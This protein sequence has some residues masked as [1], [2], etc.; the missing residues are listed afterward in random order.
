M[1]GCLRKRL[2]GQC[3][4]ARVS[5]CRVGPESSLNLVR[6]LF[7]DVRHRAPAAPPT[8]SSATGAGNSGLW[9]CPVAHATKALQ[10]SPKALRCPWQLH[11][12]CKCGARA[13]VASERG[14]RK[15]SLGLVT[16]ACVGMTQVQRLALQNARLSPAR[17]MLSYALLPSS[18][19]HTASGRVA[20]LRLNWN[21]S[22]K[23]H[24]CSFIIPEP[25]L[26]TCISISGSP[27]E[28]RLLRHCWLMWMA[29][30]GCVTPSSS[31][32]AQQ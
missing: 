19:T 27:L 4:R 21:G 29:S 32:F 25:P 22:R 10:W 30:G 1:R 8:P 28:L 11:E 26:E 6:Y 15:R 5:I 18:D 20:V 13:G 12:C 16:S 3:A 2:V 14:T 17:D 31:P 7:D 23:T 24:K 9:Q